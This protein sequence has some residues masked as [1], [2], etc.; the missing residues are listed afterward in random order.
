VRAL[1][2][3]AAIDAKTATGT[4]G[5]FVHQGPDLTETINAG[6]RSLE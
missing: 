5:D 3:Q 6:S 4:G 1:P 2:K